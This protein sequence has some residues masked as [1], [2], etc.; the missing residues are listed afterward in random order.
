M[1][2]QEHQGLLDWTEFL[3][4]KETAV[5]MAILDYQV[6]TEPLVIQEKG[7]PQ[8]CYEVAKSS[9]SRALLKAGQWIS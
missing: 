5:M 3:E 4:Q 9:N 2:L 8:V 1:E 6:L 7:E